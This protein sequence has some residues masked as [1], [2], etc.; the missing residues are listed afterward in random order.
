MA[1][2]GVAG[3]RRA[4][5]VV[6]VREPG[7]VAGTERVALVRCAGHPGV[8]AHRPAH[9]ELGERGPIARGDPGE[10]AA[11]VFTGHVEFPNKV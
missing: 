3:A 11:V 5:R 1:A 2:A 10:Q 7:N 9:G 4:G 8:Q 6:G